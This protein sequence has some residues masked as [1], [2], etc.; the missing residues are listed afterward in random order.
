M[1]ADLKD[2]RRIVVKVGTSTLT[3]KTGKMNIRRIVKLSSVLS[4]LVNSGIEVTLVSSGAIA[5]GVGKLGLKEWPEDTPGRQAAAAVG[6]CELMF[7]YDKF[8]GEY[9]HT[10]CQL[11]ITKGDFDDGERRQNLSNT[12]EKLFKYGAVPIVNENDSVAVDEIVY[13][14]NDTLSA[15]V[16][17]LIGAQALIILT[18]A[19]GLYDADPSVDNGANLI[20]IVDL[21]DDETMALASG[22][23][24]NRGTGG[25]ITKLQAAKIA[26]SSGINTVIMNGQH[27]QDIYKL[28]EGKQIGTF[29][30]AGRQGI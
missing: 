28:L 24:S 7:I 12:F 15:I 30:K 29:F 27:P 9:G 10:V 17:K 13:G 5:V 3:H 23:N 18:D 14:D 25:M 26:A 21:I 6:Q 19:D 20:P 2:V 22:S 16:A 8:F 1:M 4:D 11:L